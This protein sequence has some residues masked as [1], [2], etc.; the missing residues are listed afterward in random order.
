M[1]CYGY[2]YFRTLGVIT[3]KVL[4]RSCFIVKHVIKEF[5]LQGNLWGL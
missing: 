5:S 3:L 4:I 2:V 1:Y